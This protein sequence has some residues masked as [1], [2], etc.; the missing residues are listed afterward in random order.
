M[1]RRKQVLAAFDVSAALAESLAMP[2]AEY[3]HAAER[4]PFAGLLS[5]LVVDRAVGMVANGL[6]LVIEFVS[7]PLNDNRVA[8][9]RKLN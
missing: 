1:I 6:R 9:S 5:V 7:H 8:T 4:A 3:L 2:V